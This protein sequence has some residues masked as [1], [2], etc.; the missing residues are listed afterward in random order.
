MDPNAEAL[1]DV[2]AILLCV[3]DYLLGSPFFVSVRRNNRN[4]RTAG[5]GWVGSKNCTQL[6]RMSEETQK[7]VVPAQGTVLALEYLRRLYYF[8]L[9]LHPSTI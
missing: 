9:A 2:V 1:K 4:R 6:G 8:R 5:V 7:I 3:R